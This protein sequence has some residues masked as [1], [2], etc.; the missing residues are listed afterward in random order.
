[1]T[2][3]YALCQANV[4]KSQDPFQLLYSS[5]NVSWEFL[6]SD[7]ST[8]NIS[9][10]SMICSVTNQQ[11]P[12]SKAETEQTLVSKARHQYK[13][14]DFIFWSHSPAGAQI[15]CSVKS[16]WILNW[17]VYSQLASAQHNKI[18][19]LANHKG[20]VVTGRPWLLLSAKQTCINTVRDRHSYLN[21]PILR[22]LNMMLRN[23]QK[24]RAA[25]LSYKQILQ[26]QNHW[27]N[28]FL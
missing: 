1:M 2:A 15:S 28:W 19:G 20:I 7:I 11:R 14:T 26:L 25:T 5:C 8:P 21:F 17:D 22:Q 6:L 9:R 3:D 12:K 13:S 23:I 16:F 4:Q 27:H 18:R 10:K 24:A